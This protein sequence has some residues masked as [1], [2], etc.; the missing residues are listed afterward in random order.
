MSRARDQLILVR[1]C[2]PEDVRANRSAD[3]RGELKLSILEHFAAAARA[4]TRPSDQNAD[5]HSLRQHSQAAEPGPGCR[6]LL[7]GLNELGHHALPG[8][9]LRPGA[10]LDIIVEDTA[11]SLRAALIVEGDSVLE[12][13]YRVQASD[14]L[15]TQLAMERVGWNFHRIPATK[16]ILAPKMASDH[17]HGFLVKE[18]GF[19]HPKLANK[20]DHSSSN[21][22]S[23][24]ASSSPACSTAAAPTGARQHSAASGYN[25]RAKAA[26]RILDPSVDEQGG[27]RSAKRARNVTPQAVAALQERPRTLQ[28][29]QAFRNEL[30][31]ILQDLNVEL[32]AAQELPNSPA[33]PAMALTDAPQERNKKAEAARAVEHILAASTPKDRLGGGS[34][35][36]QKK[37]FR[38]LLLLLHPDKGLCQGADSE[39][40]LRL[41]IDAYNT[42]S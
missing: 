35:V 23:P 3:S 6:A 42:C 38:R 9:W 31:Q 34:L 30:K 10:K 36:E 4:R 39:L 40:A 17:V 15:E 27:E 29:L 21:A 1:S 16:C 18:C 33:A 2:A 19:C 26:K 14:S 41:A 25:V 22:S 12:D 32:G 5:S 8:V 37:E 13:G 7:S 28:E 11:S 20:S 24:C